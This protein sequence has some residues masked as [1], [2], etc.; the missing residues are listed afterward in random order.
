MLGKVVAVICQEPDRSV[1]SWSE[2]SSGKNALEWCVDFVHKGGYAGPERSAQNTGRHDSGHVLPSVAYNCGSISPVGEIP[3]R[4]NM[5]LA[6]V[7]EQ[8]GELNR[9]RVFGDAVI[10]SDC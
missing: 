8:G 1:N 4:Q 10:V 3:V 9:G 5:I 6:G 2:K 7:V